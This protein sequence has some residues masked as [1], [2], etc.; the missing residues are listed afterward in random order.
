MAYIFISHS[1]KDNDK[2]KE[3]FEKLQSISQSI[4]LDFDY[5]HG[6][7]GGQKWEKELYKRV[8]QDR[9]MIVA[10]SPNWLNSQWC[11]KEYCLARAYKKIVIPVIIK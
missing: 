3:I 10:I 4:F 8:K 9:I 5:I 7:K 11:Y 1:S 2:A 6:I